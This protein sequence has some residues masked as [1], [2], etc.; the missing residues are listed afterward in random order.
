MHIKRLTACALA[1]LLAISPLNLD[2]Y[3]RQAW[4]TISMSRRL[5]NTAERNKK[6]RNCKKEVDKLVP[7]G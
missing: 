6:N 5:R 4:G 1:A 2:V 7:F 3:K